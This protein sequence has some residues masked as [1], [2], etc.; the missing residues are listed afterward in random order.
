MTETSAPQSA[1]QPA[2]HPSPRRRRFGLSAQSKLLAMLLGVSLLASIVVGVIGYRSGQESLRSAA[3]EQ[4]TTVRELRAEAIER[5]FSSLQTNVELQSRNASSVEGAA[6]FIAGFE[7]LEGTEL[8][9]AQDATLTRFF[10]EEYVPALESRSGSEFE[11]ASFIP[12]T[13]PGRYLQYHYTA[14]RAIDDFDA[15]LALSDAGDGSQWSAAN[16]RYGPYFQSLVEELGYEDVLILN[17]DAEIVYSAYKSVDLGVSMREAPYE[18]SSLTTAVDEALRSGSLDSVITTDFERYLPSLGIP[19]AWVVSP[20][21]TATELTGVLAVQVPIEQI[22]AVMTGGGDWLAQGLGE[23][24]EAYLAGADGL[25]RSASRLLTEE[26]DAYA[27]TVIANGTPPEVAER[28]VRV[29]GTVLLQPVDSGALQ[30]ALRGQ[31]GTMVGPQY[32]EGSS[33]IAYAPLEIEGLNWAIIAHIDASEAFAPVNDFARDMTI[34]T[35]A[36]LLAVSVLSLL[37]AQVFVRPIRQLVDAVRRLTAGALDVRVPARSR[38]EFGDLGLAFNEMA[39]SL[40]VKQELIEEQ[41]SENERLLG[42]LLPG[43]VAARYRDGEESIAEEHEDVSVV[44]AELIG[45]DEHTRGLSGSQ[46][47]EALNALMRGFDE[48]ATTAGVERVRTLR[49][50]YLASSGLVV[51]RVDNALRAVSFAREMRAVVQRFNAQH[52]TQL[53]IRAGVDTGA[54][55]SGLV[56]RTNL[57][58]DLWGDAV[59]LAFAMRAASREPGIYVS[60]AVRERLAGS[61][62]FVEAGTVEARERTETIWSVVA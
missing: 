13:D 52:G 29:A 51:P 62:E 23:T 54:V 28:M 41:Q 35:L 46:E 44:Y 12:A 22:N 48:A 9:A 57:A 25:M 32:T 30:A 59:S 36:I 39:E 15:G 53:D 61:V 24:G 55:K 33:L 21:G 5:E 18:G 14:Q 56:A 49:G 43:S 16:A 19:T 20:I 31:S 27:A 26:P 42:T 17:T 4:L 3:F 37:L 6:A 58:Y 8:D 2:P 47:I 38:D 1:P 10:E 40:K 7:A 60:A 11:P 50:G 45:F 34:W